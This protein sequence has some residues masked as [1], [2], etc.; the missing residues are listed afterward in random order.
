[1]KDVKLHYKHIALQLKQLLTMWFTHKMTKIY[2]FM[3]RNYALENVYQ[4]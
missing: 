1:M 3:A 2:P 4:K